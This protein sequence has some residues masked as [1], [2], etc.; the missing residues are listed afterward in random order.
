MHFLRH[1]ESIV[2]INVPAES[3]TGLFGGN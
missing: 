1:G 2:S 3:N